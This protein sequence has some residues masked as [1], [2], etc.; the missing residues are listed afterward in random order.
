MLPVFWM[1][2]SAEPRQA[3]ATPAPPVGLFGVIWGTNS[4]RPGFVYL[5]GL[6]VSEAMVPG[7]RFTFCVGPTALVVLACGFQL[8]ADMTVKT[9]KEKI[10]AGGA[11]AMM[12]NEYVWG[13]GEGVEW[14][15]TWLDGDRRK[16]FFCQPEKRRPAVDRHLSPSWHR[17]R[18]H[19]PV[20]PI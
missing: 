8:K 20:L 18:A 7:L 4:S 5:F 12:A 13:L 9:Y 6:K 19:A 10:A 17:H 14:S 2:T 15:N 3:G 1:N 11:I 16:P